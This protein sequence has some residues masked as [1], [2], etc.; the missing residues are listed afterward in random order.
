MKSLTTTTT[1]LPAALR[2]NVRSARVKLLAPAASILSRKPRSRHKLFRPRS[3]GELDR[4]TLPLGE[5]LALHPA[6]E[7]LFRHQLELFKPGEEARVEERLKVRHESFRFTTLRGSKTV[8]GRP[9]SFPAPS[10]SPHSGSP[11]AP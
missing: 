2:L 7:D 3:G 5:P 9:E 10:P 8:S 11:P 1:P 6:D 4:L